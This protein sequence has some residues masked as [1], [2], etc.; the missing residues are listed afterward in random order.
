MKR[1]RETLASRIEV[2]VKLTQTHTHKT[3]TNTLTQTGNL[4]FNRK[5]ETQ[6]DRKH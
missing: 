5:G 3:L 2:E 4:Y 1:E 6:R